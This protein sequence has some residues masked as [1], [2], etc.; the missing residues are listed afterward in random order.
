MK[1]LNR[2]IKLIIFC[3]LALLI[4][5]LA[6]KSLDDKNYNVKL[7][8]INNQ[9]GVV[10]DFLV[11]I[12]KTD[13]ERERGLMWVK[14]LPQNYG[15][16]F[17]FTNEQLVYMWMK[18]TKIPLDMIFINQEGKIVHIKHQTQPES[19]EIISSINPAVKVLEINGG[20]ADKLG[21]EVGDAVKIITS[22]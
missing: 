3:S 7:Q 17:E 10:N 20:L 2:S 14:K 8:I 1:T 16:I 21:I 11:K 18:N 19:L 12:A 9:N 15:M 5:A 22:N 13:K 4:T 6:S